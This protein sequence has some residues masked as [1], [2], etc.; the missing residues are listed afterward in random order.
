MGNL[1]VEKLEENI[2]LLCPYCGNKILSHS[3]D[4]AKICLGVIA[5]QRRRAM[6]DTFMKV[7]TR[8]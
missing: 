2:P 4:Q 6:I 8:P 1:F 7:E 5:G 3:D